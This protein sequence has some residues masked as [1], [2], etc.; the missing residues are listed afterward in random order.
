MDNRRLSG[1][2]LIELLVVIAII[3]LL[4]AIIMPSLGKVKDAAKF[5]I[6][7][8]NQRQIINGVNAYAADNGTLMPPRVAYTG[9]PS[10]LNRFQD[11]SS[12]EAGNKPSAVY[13]SL[14][15]YLPVAK[16]FNCPISTYASQLVEMGG[17]QQEY[18]YFYEHP[19]DSLN[20]DAY[21]NENL[22]C[23][24]QLL[25]NYEFSPDPSISDKVFIGPGKES[26]VKLL[27]SDA[28]FF[29]NSLLSG[30]NPALNNR[31]VCTHNFSK[32]NAKISG[33]QDFP[34]KY[35]AIPNANSGHI[36]LIN[37]DPVLRDIKLNA[38]Y[39]DGR[40][41]KYKSG[42]SIKV[43][44]YANYANYWLTAQWQ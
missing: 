36:S 15:P 35:Y 28:F 2:T 14:G 44:K 33:D 23:S 43:A 10:V 21:T 34:Y 5:V 26:D 16:I 32:T 40:V 1:F 25:W 6:C 31:W 9:R 27:T 7:A 12:A 17:V 39:T 38:G 13:R 42:D 4:L 8:N 24:F 3:A 30:Y 19:Q 11:A 41:V 29:S 18:Q 22:N 37:T 20:P